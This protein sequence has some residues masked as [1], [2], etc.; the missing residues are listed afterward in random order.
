[1]RRLSGV[2]RGVVLAAA[3]LFAIVP[4]AWLVLISLMHNL[5]IETSDRL[6]PTSITLDNYKRL[7]EQRPFGR[8]L[9]NSFVVTASA[10][11]LSLFIGGT[12][13]YAL[14]RFRL[15]FRIERYVGLTLLVIRIVPPIVLLVPMFLLM[16]RLDLLNSRL[17]LILV[18]TAFGT[19]L[20]VFMM[21]SFF[22]EIPSELEEAALMDGDT[23]WGA[24]WRVVL[25]LARPGFVATGVF[26]TITLYNEFL[27]ALGLTSSPAA[28]TVP[29]GAAT[30]IAKDGVDWGALAAAGVAAAAPIV[31]LTLI[32]QRHLVRGLTFGA[33]K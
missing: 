23:Q 21:E 29:R 20:V 12:A 6:I 1:M 25:P 8:Y 9:L 17:G 14:A 15:L 5:E 4:I 18:Y 16:L 2:I 31:L 3:L 28:M 19:A 10:V 22:R 13:A 32:V 24:L 26:A 27:F 30:L 11:S 33:V 7:F